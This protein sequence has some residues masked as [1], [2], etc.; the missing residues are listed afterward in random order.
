[1]RSERADPDPGKARKPDSWRGKLYQIIFEAD[2][3]A[4]RW[5]D[6]LLIISILLSVTVVM[7]DSVHTIRSG[8]DG[9]LYALEWFFTLLFTAEYLLRLLCHGRPRHYAVSFFGVVDLL[10]ILP[11][12]ISLLSPASKFLV[13][14]RIIRILRV[15]R[16]L[17]LVQYVGEAEELMQALWA[18]RR[19]ITVFLFTVMTLVVIFGSIMYVIE[20]EG[21]GF[22]SIPRSVYWAIVTLTTVGYGD[23]SP[24][25]DTGQILA[26]IVMVLGYAIIAVPT[27]IVTA[28]MVH[29]RR[30]NRELRSCADCGSS[31]HDSDA[32]H[33]KHCG[34]LLFNG[35]A[36]GSDKAGPGAER[37]IR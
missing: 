9:T 8:Y 15:F 10:S 25:T 30:S 28:E 29:S 7:L 3:P 24:V 4:G 31:G 23:I 14:I 11:T 17:K 32:R 22:T 33:C 37:G 26:A 19:R 36:A 35:S 18:S 2:T 21:N 20:G 27:G 6:I 12:Y 1:M 5:F 16:V 13:V 34:A